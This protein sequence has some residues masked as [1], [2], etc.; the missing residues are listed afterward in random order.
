MRIGA[1]MLSVVLVAAAIWSFALVP[2]GTS[3][4]G[5]AL[6]QDAPVALMAAPGLEAPPDGSD[7]TGNPDDP[8][9]GRL[10]QA[11]LGIPTFVWADVGASK[12]E[13]EIAN[14]PA[15]GA[16]VVLRRSDLQYPTYTPTGFDERGSGLGLAEDAQSNFIDEAAFYWHVRAWDDEQRQWGE[17]SPTSTF[18][19]HWGYVPQLIAP[20]HMGTE[21]LTPSFVW[22]PVPGAS[23]YQIEV[24]T[25]SS[26]GSPYISTTT[27][28]P[29]YTPANSIPNDDDVFW[30]VR[31]FHRPNSG[32]VTGGRGGPWSATW[33]FKLAWSAKTATGDTRPLLLTPPNNANHTNRPLFCWQPVAGAKSYKIDVA[34][35]PGFVAD[36]YVVK[37]AKTEGT[38]YSFNRDSSYKLERG[39]TYYWRVVAVD[40]KGYSGQ[41]TDEGTASAPFQF[42]ASPSDPPVVPSLLYPF[43]Y[44]APVAAE[45]F[46]DRTATVPTFVWDHVEGASYYQL[47]VDDDP[48][49]N[50]PHIF[51]A[52]TENASYTFTDSATYPLADGQVYYWK[53][54]SDLSPEW[55][56]L[57]T[58]WAVR[59]DTTQLPVREAVQQLQPT[60]QAEP[61]TG[62]YLY[63]QESVTYYPS[64]SW[65]AVAPRGQARYRI[66]IALD[67]GFGQLVDDGETDFTEFTPAGRPE[68]GTYYWRV[69]QITPAA[70]PWS[71]VGRF[72]VARNFRYAEEPDGAT[73]GGWIVAAADAY[74]PMGEDSD[75]ASANLTAL[76]PVNSSAAWYFALPVEPLGARV[77]LY[78]DT[79]HF[80]QSGAVMPPAGRTG[81]AVPDAHRPEYALYWDGDTGVTELWH[82]T[83]T[84]WEGGGPLSGI[85]G[86][87]YHDG[88]MLVMKVPVTAINRPASLGLLAFTFDAANTVLD[89][90]P[91]QPGQAGVAAFLTEST[92]PTPLFPANAPDDPALATVERNTPT[93]IWR[94]HDALVPQGVM[95][96]L[97]FETFQDDT[98]SVLYESEN[99][100]APTFNKTSMQYFFDSNY[101]WAPQVHYSDNSSYNWRI[102]RS[103]WS[104]SAPNN[105]AKAGYIPTGLQVQPTVPGPDPGV[106]YTDRTPSFSWTPVQSAVRYRWELYEGSV[107][108]ADKEV[109]APYYTPSEALKD[110]TF[111]WKVWAIDAR[112]RLSQ[113]AAQGSFSKVSPLVGDLQ[114]DFGPDGLQVSW[115]P[116]LQAAY[117]K[118]LIASDDQF[119]RNL[120][121][122]TTH[123][124]VFTPE[125]VPKAARSGSFYVRVLTCDNNGQEGPYVEVFYD[126]PRVLL[127]AIF[128]ED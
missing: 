95:S 46:E 86:S 64:F 124:S 48:A 84:A 32:S 126:P 82:W 29:Y 107:R 125:A 123:N 19:R 12:Y 62:G 115:Q 105:F 100:K 85:L 88:T 99:G 28:V 66:E 58:R 55:S 27:E 25:S 76:Y 51:E 5:A 47:L 71:S 78:L 38:C 75:A 109:M 34:T 112:G 67:P 2:A 54:R 80:D 79:D 73:D 128:S 43:H 16:S 63:G 101:H 37:G 35:N 98:F 89:L 31:A 103:G 90:L 106:T 81:P 14:T 15:F 119:S 77:G 22:E 121:T 92:T 122:Y 21:S 44:Y 56:A 40:A 74:T 61:W 26:F 7:F 83:G 52:T 70:G 23:F 10:L 59:V 6:A 110:G 65:T 24:D 45:G 33:Q 11:P 18:T 8:V 42:Q 50:P 57:N 60:Y 68:P 36:S 1:R 9:P 96:A 53:V 117:Y 102:Q 13:L 97:V 93:L 113:E 94:H 104:A 108:R 30:R 41:P 114:L 17:F 39:T 72:I 111:T 127:P 116:V 49:M 91:N 3:L 4:A 69:R 118:V 20:V 87:A 120:Q